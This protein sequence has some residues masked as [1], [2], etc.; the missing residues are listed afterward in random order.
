[1]GI[2][3][4]IWATKEVTG[5]KKKME[6]QSVIQCKVEPLKNPLNLP[7]KFSMGDPDETVT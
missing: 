3:M 1:M 5:H 2:I 6:T 4:L 7:G